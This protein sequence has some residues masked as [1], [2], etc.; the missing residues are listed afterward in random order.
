MEIILSLFILFG[1][2]MR[3]TESVDESGALTALAF[4][5]GLYFI[6]SGYT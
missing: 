2:V 6:F 3:I 5:G 4:F 1:L